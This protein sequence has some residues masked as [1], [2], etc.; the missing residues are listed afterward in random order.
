MGKIH[1]CKNCHSETFGLEFCI[2]NTN[3]PNHLVVE[4]KSC[5]M[6]IKLRIGDKK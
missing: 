3:R 5:K 2:F 6:S 4:C 1:R